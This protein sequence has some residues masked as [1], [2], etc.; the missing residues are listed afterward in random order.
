MAHFL[1]RRATVFLLL[2]LLF[3]CGDNKSTGPVVDPG[4]PSLYLPVVD[5]NFGN[6]PQGG[7]ISYPFM[8]KN[9][10]GDTLRILKITPG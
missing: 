10:G 9:T 8:I 4:P 1:T 2:A 3:A 5:F 6:V 7:I